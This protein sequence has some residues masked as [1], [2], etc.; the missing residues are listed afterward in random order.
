MLANCIEAED[1]S[2]ERAIA[3]ATEQRGPG[4]EERISITFTPVIVI[5]PP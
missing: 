3:S 5:D 1:R 2:A 4:R